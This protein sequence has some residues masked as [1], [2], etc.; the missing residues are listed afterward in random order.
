LHHHLCR[1]ASQA[2]VEERR[3]RREQSRHHAGT[4]TEQKINI[5]KGNNNK[6]NYN[7]E[8]INIYNLFDAPANAGKCPN[9]IGRR[10]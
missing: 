9:S 6:N 4:D 1:P 10:E 8:K 2:Q 5:T 3:V 7:Y